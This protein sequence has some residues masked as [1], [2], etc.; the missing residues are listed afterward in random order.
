MVQADCILLNG[1]VSSAMFS[2]KNSI[3]GPSACRRSRE[4]FSNAVLNKHH[5]ME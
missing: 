3:E 2:I 5:Y 1:N 4:A